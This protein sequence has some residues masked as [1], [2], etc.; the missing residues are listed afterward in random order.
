MIGLVS[1]MVEQKGLDIILQ[2][3]ADILA[4]P[5]QLVMLGTGEI[6]YEM[7]LAEWAREH[8]EQLKVIIGYNESLSHQVEAGSDLFLMP[9]AFEPCGL[10]QLYSLRYGTLPIVRDVGGLADTVIDASKKNVANASANGFVVKKQT[11]A[12]LLATLKRA[13]KLYAQTDIW[14]QLQ[15]TAMNGDFSWQASAKHYIDLYSQAM[16]DKD[17]AID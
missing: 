13:L 11:A 7:Q 12:A 10:N 14:R 1:R 9:S 2:G 4:L 8:P 6:H 17:I 3:M 15:V 16:A 5:V